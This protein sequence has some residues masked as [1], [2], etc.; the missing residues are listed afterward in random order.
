MNI[1]SRFFKKNER[2]DVPYIQ[3]GRHR[4]LNDRPEMYQYWSAAVKS[5]ESEKYM[6]AF[7]QLMEF[8]THADGSNLTYTNKNGKL[9]FSMLQGSKI[10]TGYADFKVFWAQAPIVCL[11]HAQPTILHQLLEEN[12]EL[13]YGRYALD[14]TD[15]IVLYFDT[16]VEDAS[17]DRIY[18]ALVE[19]ATI[20][21]GKDDLLLSNYQGLSAINQPHIRYLSEEVVQVKY[22][23]FKKWVHETTTEVASGRLNAEEYPGGISFLLLD[24]LYKIDFLI[25]PEG[26][27]MDKIRTGHTL[28]FEDNFTSVFEKNRT[29]GDLL[30]SME[31]YEYVAFRKEN[32]NVVSTF[33]TVFPEG[34]DRMAELVRVHITDI[35]WY[36]ANGYERYAQAICN[37]VAGYSLYIYDLPAMYVA[38]MML[39]Y[40][41]LEHDFFKALGYSEVLVN[42]DGMPD[43]SRIVKSIK[44]IAN[45]YSS[46]DDV[47]KLDTASLDYTDKVTFSKSY[48]LM[49][50]NLETN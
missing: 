48:L 7:C 43:K 32:Y 42:A 1:I 21:D 35:D 33:G 23:F 49:I 14:P 3:M 29:I 24:C 26:R 13:K 41:V 44:Q 22:D 10:I 6:D 31:N 27:L 19:L 4:E 47:L 45:Q 38:L 40:K 36:H 39:Y 46:E 5:F 20:A 11:E 15:N 9:T 12:Y 8:L 30:K 28:Y 50:S 18:N 34:R 25:K 37:F 17:P 16:L 2:L